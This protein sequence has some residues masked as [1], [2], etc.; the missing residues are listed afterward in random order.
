MASLTKKTKRIRKNKRVKA[1]RRRKRAI[2]KNGTTPPF[3]IHVS[4]GPAGPPPAGRTVARKQTR[5][6]TGAKVARIPLKSVPSGGAKGV[7]TEKKTEGKP[8][9][10]S[11]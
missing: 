4:E 11:E 3:P 2:R 8:D 10:R 5:T 9:P 7:A 1:G 6:V